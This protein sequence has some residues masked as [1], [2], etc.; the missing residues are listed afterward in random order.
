MV[1][2]EDRVGVGDG[3]DDVAGNPR[4][5]AR[6]R[7]EKEHPGAL[8][9]A[10][11]QPSLDEEL[12]VP[13]DARLRLAEDGHKLAHGQF[14]IAKQGQQAQARRLAGGRQGS[15]DI[16]KGRLMIERRHTTDI[17]ISL[18]LSKDFLLQQCLRRP[19]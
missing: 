8:A 3:A 14:G 16:L 9:M 18:C 10:L 15:K 7:H 4:R 5:G 12:Q 6:M 11:D 1:R 2:D 13:R 17:K 19:G